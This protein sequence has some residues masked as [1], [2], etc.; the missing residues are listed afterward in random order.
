MHTETPHHT[1]FDG[2]A[3]QTARLRLRPFQERD[4]ASILALFMDKGFMEYASAPM[5]Q[6]IEEAH[7][8]VA[9]DAAKRAA[10][11]RLRLGMERL[12]DGAVIGY[13]DLFNIDRDCRKGEIGYGLLTKERGFG[14][15][16]E[17]LTAFLHCVLH[18]LA[19]NR[20]MAEINPANTNSEKTVQRLGFTKEGHF[21]ENCIVNGVVSD[22]VFY[23]LLKRDWERREIQ[24]HHPQSLGSGSVPISGHLT[25]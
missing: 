4:A 3:L 6:S 22:S 24:H 12:E 19:L 11:E 14:L 7:A 25:V 21:R 9:R 8:L 23:G 15:M 10:G 13:C 17:A 18:V 1:S 16:H 2:I 20:V 5:F